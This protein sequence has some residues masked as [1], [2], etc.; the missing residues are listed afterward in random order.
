MIAWPKNIHDELSGIDRMSIRNR[1]MPVPIDGRLRLTPGERRDQLYRLAVE[2]IAQE[3]VVPGAH[4]RIAKDAGVSVATVFKYFRKAAD[5]EDAVIHYVGEV[6]YYIYNDALVT[7]NATT[8]HENL[9]I[10]LADSYRS[11]WSLFRAWATAGSTPQKSCYTS[12]VKV[13]ENII[14]LVR[15]KIE[16]GRRKGTL[17]KM[18]MKTRTQAEW[19]VSGLRRLGELEEGAVNKQMIRQYVELVLG[20][21][22]S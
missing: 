18:A 7:E 13:E 21:G 2:I 19:L 12:F 14:A 6:M 20:L 17:P 16:F 9:C 22:R 10:V 11:H 3:G 8:W 15:S 1:V 5:L 4:A